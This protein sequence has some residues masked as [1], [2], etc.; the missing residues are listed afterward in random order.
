MSRL[1][2]PNQNHT[3]ISSAIEETEIYLV[4][5]NLSKFVTHRP[6][7]PENFGGL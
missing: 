7:L 3:T 1:W 4:F 5:L 6:G 2:I